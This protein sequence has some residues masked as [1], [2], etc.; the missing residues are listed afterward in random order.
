[1]GEQ[2]WYYNAR[3]FQPRRTGLSSVTAQRAVLEEYLRS[4]VAALTNVT[5]LE[6]TELLGLLSTP[7]GTRVT[8]ARLRPTAP[9]TADESTLQADLFVDATGRG[10]RTPVWLQEM[11]Y[12]RPAETRMPI[13]LAYTTRLYRTRP[14]VPDGARFINC[15]AS[16]EFPR[17]AFFGQVD[18]RT[19]LLSLT[20]LHGDHP[21]TDP[22]GFHRFARSLPVED[23]HQHIREAEP[24]TDPVSFRFP[25]SLRRR[26]ERLPRLP[27]R[28]LVLGDAVG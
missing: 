13:V 20:G 2:R 25:A 3:Q 24:I 18:P 8:G 27:E 12:E 11:G 19:T 23:I 17:G 22:D 9:E 16:P 7:D 1:M 15:I 5:F 21:P 28:L 14:N 4:K 6:R 10:S 26:Y